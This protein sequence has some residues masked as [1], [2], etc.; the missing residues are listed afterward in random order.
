MTIKPDYSVLLRPL[1]EDDG[2]G[3]IAIVPD[4][5]GCYSDG[6]TAMEAL[7]SVGSAIRAWI[8]TAEKYGKTVP[9]PDDFIDEAF[10]EMIPPEIKRQAEIIARQMQDLQPGQHPDHSLLSAIYAEMARATIRRADL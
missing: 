3:W 8:A 4:L 9:K 10:P 5:P 7:E 2:G 1:S 6:P